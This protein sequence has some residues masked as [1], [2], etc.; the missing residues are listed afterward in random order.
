[1]VYSDGQL[2]GVVVYSNDQ[3]VDG[4]VYSD[5]QLVGE[6]VHSNDQLVD[7]VV[8]SDG[9]L[10]GEVVC[11]NDQLVDDV[12]YSDDQLLGE[13]VYSNE[14]RDRGLLEKKFLFAPK[15]VV[16]MRKFVVPYDVSKVHVYPL[17]TTGKHQ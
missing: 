12:V 1:M 10:V 5:G 4:V 6:V 17:I 16:L 8:Y 13:V 3:L 9:Q 14:G 15:I 11:S 7:G 2:V